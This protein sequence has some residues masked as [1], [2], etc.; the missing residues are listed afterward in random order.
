MASTTETPTSSSAGVG[1]PLPLPHL[2][3]GCSW[4]GC[5]GAEE[6]TAGTEGTRSR[7]RW[8]GGMEGIQQDWSSR[9]VGGV[10]VTVVGL[11]DGGSRPNSQGV[12]P[13]G[14]GAWP[15]HDTCV[16]S[17]GVGVGGAGAAVGVGV[18][19]AV[20]LAG[21]GVAHTSPGQSRH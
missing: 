10:A 11:P 4:A 13:G 15:A 8:K 18:A 5:S 1:L 2:L 9:T 14:L 12:P 17:G 19:A 20:A 3:A 6:L 16:G 21:A 7:R